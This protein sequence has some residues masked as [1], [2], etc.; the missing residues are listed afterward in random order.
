MQLDHGPECESLTKE[1]VEGV[2]SELVG[3]HLKG[4]WCSCLSYLRIG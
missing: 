4:V 2:G 3:L 1:V